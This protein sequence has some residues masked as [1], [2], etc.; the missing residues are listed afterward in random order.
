M[1]SSGTDLSIF[2]VVSK[3][4]PEDRTESSDEDDEPRGHA[5]P[6]KARKKRELEVQ[7]RKK[8]RVYERLVKNGHF[9]SGLP[10]NQNE[11]FHGLSAWRIQQYHALKKRNPEASSEEF[12]DYTQAFERFQN[13]LKEFTEESLRA[14]VKCVCKTLVRVLSRCL[15]FSLH[16]ESQCFEKGKEANIEDVGNTFARGTASSRE[17]N[18]RP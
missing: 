12:T 5:A 14:R 3:L 8:T 18:P 16:S 4:E 15:D 6:V 17:H 11:R 10:M 13:S 2:F 9:P 7:N 1:T